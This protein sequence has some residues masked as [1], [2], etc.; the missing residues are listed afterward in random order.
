MNNYGIKHWLL[1]E[2]PKHQDYVE[3]TCNLIVTNNVKEERAINLDYPSYNLQVKAL[4][5]LT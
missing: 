3:M 4:T 5:N 2:E 1:H